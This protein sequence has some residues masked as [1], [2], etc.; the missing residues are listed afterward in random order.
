[1]GKVTW[2]ASGGTGTFSPGDNPLSSD[3]SEAKDTRFGGHREHSQ[4]GKAQDY[5]ARTGGASNVKENPVDET[6]KDIDEMTDPKQRKR[7]FSYQE[8]KADAQ[9]NN[10]GGFISETDSDKRPPEDTDAFEPDEKLRRSKIKGHFG[11]GQYDNNPNRGVYE[12]E[13]R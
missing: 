2:N 6:I 9:R 11:S 7:E 5:T 3:Q 4:I 10:E 13:I 1:M 8:D 12:G